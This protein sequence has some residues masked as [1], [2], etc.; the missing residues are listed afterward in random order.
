MTTTQ[1]AGCP[2]CGTWIAAES[3][4]CICGFQ[5]RHE[6][7]RAIAS[8]LVAWVAACAAM[9]LVWALPLSL[10]VWPLGLLALVSAAYGVRCGLQAVKG[11]ALDKV[12]GTMA[13][14][15]C[16]AVFIVPIVLLVTARLR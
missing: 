9:F 6:A 3:L 10:C 12:L 15:L 13:L 14:L 1:G 8:G 7:G 4:G 5:P 16:A 11:R 2:S